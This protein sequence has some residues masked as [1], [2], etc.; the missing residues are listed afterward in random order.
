MNQKTFEADHAGIPELCQLARIPRHDAAPE[1]DIYTQLVARAFQ[2]CSQIIESGGGRNRVQR[3][4][5]DRLDTARR[6]G[7]RLRLQAFT[8]PSYLPVGLFIRLP[9][10]AP[11]VFF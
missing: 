3:H 9:Q 10:L 2:L 11:Y 1:S 8:T 6:P 7:A 5:Y 4:F